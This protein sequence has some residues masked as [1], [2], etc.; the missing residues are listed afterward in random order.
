MQVS[1]L[2]DNHPTATETWMPLD[3]DPS[4]P[5]EKK[6]KKRLSESGDERRDADT[7]EPA[8]SSPG[9]QRRIIVDL[10]ARCPLNLQTD[11]EATFHDDAP[12]L[13]LTIDDGHT[14]ADLKAMLLESAALALPFD[15]QPAA[16]V[17][18]NVW[19]HGDSW[20]D[21]PGVATHKGYELKVTSF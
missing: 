14:V 3:F 19:D 6:E 11:V 1:N 13:A 17:K 21:S 16:A 18:D 2:Y 7:R 5:T 4:E 15:L 10:P 20:E 8:P 12:S 9:Q